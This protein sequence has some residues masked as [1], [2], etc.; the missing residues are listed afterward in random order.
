MCSAEQR[1][2]LRKGVQ[3]IRATRPILAADFWGDGPLTGG[4]LSAGRK[5]LHINNKGDVEPCIFAHF[6]VD[7]I[8]NK[9]L[10]DCLDSDFFK[11][12]RKVQPFGK[13]L[14]RPCPIIDHPSILKRA[15]QKN[16]AYPT[17]EG[18]DSL[19]DRLEPGLHEY[20]AKVKERLD[21]VWQNDLPWV[22]KW[23]TTDGDYSRR[24]GKPGAP[25]NEDEVTEPETVGARD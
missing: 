6:A 1:E 2:Q 3:H 24:Y 8:R 4:C 17:H 15:V 22:H 12:I 23:L 7:N 14:L 18:A 25:E 13:N 20:A 10:I 11:D 21:P 9:P 19:F 5:Y 16:G